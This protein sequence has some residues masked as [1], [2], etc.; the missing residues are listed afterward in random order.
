M[1]NLPLL[2]PDLAN[3][4]QE[5][6]NLKNFNDANFWNEKNNVKLDKFKKLVKDFYID[7]QHYTCVYCRQTIKVSHNGAW[8]LEHIVSRKENPRWTLEPFNLCIACKDCNSEK[9]DKEVLRKKVVKKIPHDESYYKIYHPHIDDYS[10]HITVV[11][12]G[13]FY[14]PE[15]K[16][17]RETISICGLDRFFLKIAGV[18]RKTKKNSYLIR[19]ILDVIDRSNDEE[20]NEKLYSIIEILAGNSKILIKN[21]SQEK[22][23][24]AIVKV[25]KELK[26]TD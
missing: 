9:L 8:D 13:E 15:T 26:I 17:G 25:L 24:E 16:K 12:V 7:N 14:L 4:A 22:M 11:S 3:F 21:S 5:F 19:K 18:G 10:K 20:K 6:L 2:D 1:A 23:Q